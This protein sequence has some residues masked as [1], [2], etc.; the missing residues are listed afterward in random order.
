MGRLSVIM[1]GLIR[2]KWECQ[3]QRRRRD[4]K[5]RDQSDAIDGFE[6]GRVP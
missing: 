1:K 2:K 5:N 6:D 4:Y 3:S